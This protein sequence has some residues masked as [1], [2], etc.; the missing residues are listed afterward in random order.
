MIYS[1]GF[2]IE[3]AIGLDV[4]AS[5]NGWI[6][7]T[8]HLEYETPAYSARHQWRND[9]ARCPK[10][11]V[12]L[13][14]AKVPRLAGLKKV[15]GKPVDLLVHGRNIGDDAMLIVHLTDEGFELSDVVDML[16]TSAL[17]QQGEMV[18][19]ITGKSVRTV[20]RLLKE[21][22]PVRLD[23]QQSVIAYQYALVLELA[24]EAFGGQPRAEAWMQNPSTYFHG[25]VPLELTRHPLGF[26]MVEQYLGQLIHGVYP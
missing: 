6:M 19:R 1:I 14:S 22:R 15:E 18:R 7:R 12:A 24:I 16:S 9:C 11:D 8:A 10:E 3:V 20:R 5:D 4:K 13:P 17:Y 25:R 26:Q 2:D 21:G 23:P